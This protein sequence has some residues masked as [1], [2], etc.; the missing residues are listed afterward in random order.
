MGSVRHGGQ[1]EIHS[2]FTT[3]ICIVPFVSEFWAIKAEYYA[4]REWW[5]HGFTIMTSKQSY[6]TC[7]DELS[8][9][10]FSHFPG[11]TCPET[12]SAFTISTRPWL[13]GL[14]EWQRVLV[15]PFQWQPF[16]PFNS[17]PSLEWFYLYPCIPAHYSVLR[18]IMNS[19]FFEQ[20]LF[21]LCVSLEPTAI[22]RGA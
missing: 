7:K 8:K 18:P 10:R 9:P 4:L 20:F 13:D 2:M 15:L 11:L 6:T 19:S 1:N 16:T 21:P 5:K 17:T 12:E 3:W 14:I 22:K